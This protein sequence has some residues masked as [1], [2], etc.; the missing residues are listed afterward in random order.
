M[1]FGRTYGF[2]IAPISYPSPVLGSGTS[3]AMAFHFSHATGELVLG[4]HRL[5]WEPGVGTQHC[6]YI[7]FPCEAKKYYSY[8]HWHQHLRTQPV[9]LLRNVPKEHLPWLTQHTPFHYSFFY[10]NGTC[11]LWCMQI[12]VAHNLI[13]ALAGGGG[14]SEGR[15]VLLQVVPTI[16][17][18]SVSSYPRPICKGYLELRPALTWP[19]PSSLP[20]C[21]PLTSRKAGGP[22]ARL[23]LAQQPQ[24]PPRPPRPPLPQAASSSSK[25]RRN[26]RK[27]QQ[28][29]ERQRALCDS[30]SV[31]IAS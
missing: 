25:E 12:D 3:P 20:L 7:H 4:D 21:P 18:G 23:A 10:T 28:Q 2:A 1:R 30:S 13:H 11:T 14:W 5:A 17:G 26:R 19:G 22:P 16:F 6:R 27:Q 24:P 31:L 29:R 8:P 9:F 15:P